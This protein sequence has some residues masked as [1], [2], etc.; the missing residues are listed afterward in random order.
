MHPPEFGGNKTPEIDAFYELIYVDEFARAAGGFI[1]GQVAID[2]MAMPPIVAFGSDYIKNLVCRDVVAGRKSI[3]LC[4]SEPGAGSD[5]ANIQASAKKTADGQHYVVN[6]SKKWI[7]GGMMADYFTVAVRTGDEG[8]GGISLLL[9][10]AGMPGLK[11]RKMETQFD[12][13]HSTT[14]VTMENVKVP[15]RNLIGEENGGFMALMT[16]CACFSCVSRSCRCWR[17]VWTHFFNF[18]IF[19]S[20]FTLVGRSQPRAM[21]TPA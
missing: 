6:G 18:M 9:L 20:A 19:I 4:I 11:V 8:M 10:E 14:F 7:T 15:V 13:A 12:S 21:G 17:N 1:M 5:V 2:S 3:C 16:N